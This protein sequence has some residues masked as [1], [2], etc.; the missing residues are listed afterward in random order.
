M[1][2]HCTYLCTSVHGEQHLL[3]NPKTSLSDEGN[4]L[5]SKLKKGWKALARNR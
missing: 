5:S 1:P 4:F 2:L 3:K